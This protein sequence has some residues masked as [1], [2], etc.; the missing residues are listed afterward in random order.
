[1]ARVLRRKELELRDQEHFRQSGGTLLERLRDYI[2]ACDAVVL[3]I[4]RRSGDF[5]TAEHSAVLGEIPAFVEYCKFSGQTRASYTQ[6]EYF[7]AKHY[8]KQVY[9]FVSD[10]QFAADE[11]IDDSDDARASQTAYRCWIEQ[12]GE[13]RSPFTTLGKLVEDV[14]VLDFPGRRSAATVSTLPFR[15]LGTLFKGREAF[16]TRLRESLLSG[17]MEDMH[18]TVRAIYGLGGVGKTRVAVEYAQRH[19]SEFCAL[20]F[21]TA[22]TPEDLR[23]NIAG[24]T[25]PLVLPEATEKDEENR[26]FAALRWLREHPGWFLIIDNVDTVEAAGAVEEMVARMQGGQVVITTRIAEWSASVEPLDLDL[27]SVDDATQFLLDRTE[28]HRFKQSSDRRDAAD[29]ARELDGLALALEQAGAYISHRRCSL[30]DYCKSWRNHLP[31][32]QGWHNPQLMQ[33]PRSVAVTWQTTMQRVSPAAAAL[34]RLLGWFAPEP[35]PLSVLESDEALIWREATES[36]RREFGGEAAVEMQL[37]DA[38]AELSS[39]SMIRWDTQNRSVSVHRVV[40]ELLCRRV[41]EDKRPDWLGW[42]LQLLTATI[43]GDP[44][45]AATVGGWK[46]F[47]AHAS[48]ALAHVRDV[49]PSASPA[50]LARNVGIH[51]VTVGLFKDGMA[52]L[53]LALEWDGRSEIHL[54]NRALDLGLLGDALR[55]TEQLDEAEPLLERAKDMVDAHAEFTPAA[56]AVVLHA[57]ADLRRVQSR[58]A[59]AAV[60]Y[61]R[62][63]AIRRGVFGEQHR[64]VAKTYHAI[65]E[66]DHD[67]QIYDEAEKNYKTALSIVNRLSPSCPFEAATIQ[68]DLGVLNFDCGRKDEALAYYQSALTIYAS[69]LGENHHDVAAALHNIA[70]VTAQRGDVA[71]AL[72]LWSR[73]YAI[74]AATFPDGHRKRR[75]CEGPYVDALMHAPPEMVDKLDIPLT[76]SLLDRMAWTRLNQ[77]H[78]TAAV[79]YARREVKL[80][81]T[82]HGPDHAVTAGALNTLARCQQDQG[83]HAAALPNC[84]R[85]LAIREKCLPPTHEDLATSLNNLGLSLFSLGAEHYPEAERHLLRSAAWANYP[86]PHYWLAKLYRARGEDGDAQRELKHWR[87]Y[88]RFAAI[89]PRPRDEAQARAAE[90]SAASSGEITH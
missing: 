39:Y 26:V 81:E 1:M 50:A 30:A 14:L 57:Y 87:E 80:A 13:Y 59:E 69:I 56:A 85:A 90:L 42:S 33:Y 71:A 5:P 55:V 3:L 36:C 15:T 25:G 27:L 47:C 7:L 24:L 58:F 35:I 83:E 51:F 38:V 62:V 86:F 17:A 4:G 18:L 32:V 16:M 73:A 72:K 37:F 63:L 22:A 68:N 53:Q 10:E 61:Q 78:G 67:Q 31:A 40:Q 9:V 23:R 43:P 52:A 66:L 12:K 60:E 75:T 45:D 84:R 76:H 29:L 48:H 8:R 89:D 21:V 54:E 41:P 2:R 46:V 82:E 79:D 34:L 28:R 65:A 44:D 19:Q 49:A 11:E 88:L 70:L 74:L 20:L 64:L 77:G 6:W